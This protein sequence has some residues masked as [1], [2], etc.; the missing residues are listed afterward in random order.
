[1][2]GGLK[3]MNLSQYRSWMQKRIEFLN[4]AQRGFPEER[5]RFHP[6]YGVNFGPRL[7][8][9]QLDQVM[10]LML[11]IMAGACPSRRPTR[12]TATSGASRASSTC[13]RG[14]SSSRGDPTR[15]PCEPKP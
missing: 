4:H 15:T 11:T 13:P 10:D 9:L 14:K 2:A 8:D 3:N 5:I 6:C 12:A 7:C 1:M